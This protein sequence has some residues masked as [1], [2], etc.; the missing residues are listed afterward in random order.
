MVTLACKI[1][2]FSNQWKVQHFGN[3]KNPIN[4]LK[5]YSDDDLK[6]YFVENKSEKLPFYY[7]YNNGNISSNLIWATKK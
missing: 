6:R 1:N 4:L 7:G 2:S 3:Y 5:G